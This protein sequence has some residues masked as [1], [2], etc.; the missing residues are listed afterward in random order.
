MI[1]AITSDSLLNA[2]RAEVKIT[3]LAFAAMIVFVSYRVTT[4]V[5][6]NAE[7]GGAEVVESWQSW[8]AE[9]CL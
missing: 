9:F 7:G 1:L 4:M 6:V 2:G 8:P 5:A 3:H